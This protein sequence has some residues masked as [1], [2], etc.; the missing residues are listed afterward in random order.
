MFP[1]NSTIVFIRKESSYRQA[2]KSRGFSSADH[3][4][5]ICCNFILPAGCQA[6]QGEQLELKERGKERSHYTEGDNSPVP[7]S[8]STLCEEQF[9]WSA[10]TYNQCTS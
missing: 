3:D 7:L 2:G 10:V 6:G 8:R 5:F 4:A 9:Q 1:L